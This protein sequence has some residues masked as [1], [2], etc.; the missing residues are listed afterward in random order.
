MPFWGWGGDWR[1]FVGMRC[2]LA[3]LT[4]SN[5]WSAKQGQSCRRLSDYNTRPIDSCCTAIWLHHLD[6]EFVFLGIHVVYPMELI[7]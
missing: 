2:T 5:P 1:Q 3:L 4:A 7:L 6:A